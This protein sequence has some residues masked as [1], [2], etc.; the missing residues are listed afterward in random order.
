MLTYKDPTFKAE[1]I[2]DRV[3]YM[4]AAVRTMIVKVKGWSFDDIAEYLFLTWLI[5]WP[6]MKHCEETESKIKDETRTL[7]CEGCRW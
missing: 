6:G 4:V 3:D 1:W 5:S 7:F 2:S